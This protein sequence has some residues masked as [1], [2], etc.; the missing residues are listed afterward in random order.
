M[1]TVPD[2][3]E[4]EKV[5]KTYAS[6]LQ[7]LRDVT[8]RVAPGEFVSLLG[9]SGCGKSTG[10][11]PVSPLAGR[12]MDTLRERPRHF[13]EIA[14]LHLD[15][16]WREFLKAWGEVRDSPRIGRQEYGLYVVKDP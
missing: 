11:L 14:E 12:I 8:F 3:V 15:V 6:G 7:A 4:I 5:C 10:G 9:P 2:S 16:P 1:A 13:A